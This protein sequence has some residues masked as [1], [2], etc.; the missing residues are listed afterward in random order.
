LSLRIRLAA[1]IN[2]S[3]AGD[4]AIDTTSGIPPAL[5]RRVHS[6]CA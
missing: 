6:G 3:E 5:Q 2:P 1:G 4:L